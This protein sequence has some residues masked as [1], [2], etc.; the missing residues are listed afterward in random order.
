MFSYGFL[1]KDTPVLA[2]EQRLTNYAQCIHWMQSR[3]PMVNEEVMNDRNR[4][5]ERRNSML[6]AWLDDDDCSSTMPALA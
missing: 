1:C 3:R 6:S 5:Q 4:W 2:N